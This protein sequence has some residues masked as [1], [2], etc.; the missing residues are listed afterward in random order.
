MDLG[1][2]YRVRYDDG[3]KKDVVQY[4]DGGQRYYSYPEVIIPL[5]KYYSEE[6]VYDGH[7]LAF[8]GPQ[9]SQYGGRKI[10]EW[11][12]DPNTRLGDKVQQGQQE[13]DPN[14]RL[15]DKVSDSQPGQQESD[16]NTF[17]SDKVSGSH[18]CPQFYE[19]DDS[20]TSLAGSCDGPLDIKVVDIPSGP[21]PFYY[22]T[23]H[24]DKVALVTNGSFYSSDPERKD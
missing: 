20:K 12:Y 22:E 19:S 17:L 15:G 7:S 24:K 1:Y 2:E 23:F 4:E 16:S 6:R 21:Q 10:G 3:P 13:I 11:L 8:S 9:Y 18:I 5:E 14:T